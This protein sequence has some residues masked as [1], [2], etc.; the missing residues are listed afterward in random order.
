MQRNSDRNIFLGV[1]ERVRVQRLVGNDVIL[2]QRLK[3]ALSTR[4]KEKGKNLRPKNLEATVIWRE[5]CGAGGVGFRDIRCQ[6][7]FGESELEGRE[8]AR[9]VR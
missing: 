4:A 8:L 1:V 6:P 5:E 7:C 9:E 2:Q 3:V